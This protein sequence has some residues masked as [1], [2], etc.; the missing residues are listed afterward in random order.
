MDRTFI[1]PYGINA[2]GVHYQ[3]P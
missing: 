3:S 2:T 1:S